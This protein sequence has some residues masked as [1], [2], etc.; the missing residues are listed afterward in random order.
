M[1]IKN[2]NYRK[3]FIIQDVRV[4][5]PNYYTE[6][7]LR[8]YSSMEIGTGW[9]KFNKMYFLIGKN[10]IWKQMLIEVGDPWGFLIIAL[11]WGTGLN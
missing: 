10:V 4:R 9:I 1:A 6:I 5:I 2:R 3:V 11:E 8:G 7:C